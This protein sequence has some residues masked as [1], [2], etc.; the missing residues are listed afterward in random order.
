[1][2]RAS[3]KERIWKANVDKSQFPLSHFKV[4]NKKKVMAS[5]YA[6]S[7]VKAKANGSK[8]VEFSL[9]LTGQEFKASVDLKVRSSLLKR[10]GAEITMDK[11]G[12]LDKDSSAG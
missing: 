11:T 3:E 9:C 10:G 6:V 5:A 8:H 4:D 1:M 12:R 2:L 7:N